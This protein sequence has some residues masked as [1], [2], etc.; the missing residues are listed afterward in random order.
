LHPFI[1]FIFRF[2]AACSGIALVAYTIATTIRVFVLPRGENA[3]LS[4]QVFRFVYQIFLLAAY[5]KKTY[6]ERDAIFALFAPVVLLIQPVIYMT[7]FA[8]GF[9]P[10]YWAIDK[11]PLSLFSL[12]EAFFLSGSSLTTLGFAAVDAHNSFLQMIAFSEAALGMIFVALLIAY[13]PTIYSAFSQR[14]TQVAML[15][16]RAGSPPDGVTMITRVFRNS[17]NHEALDPLWERWEQW[18][19]QIEESHTSL[20]ALVFFRSPMPDR[21]WVTAAGA[22]LDA[23]ALLDSTVDVPRSVASVL[24]IRAGYVSLRRIA[25]FFGFI[26]YNSSPSPD[27][28]VS[29]GQDE[30]DDA[31]DA[32]Q[33]AGVPVKADREQA[34][35]DYAGWRVNY[36]RVLL[37]LAR[38]T[39][40]PYAPWSSDRS[41][42][43]MKHIPGLLPSEGFEYKPQ[44]EK[45]AEQAR[46]AVVDK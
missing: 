44:Y 13:M 32:L 35:R 7:L 24:C 17:G 9:T 33:E 34:W 1:D 15:E 4:R 36:D 42:P 25:D 38:L 8:I 21:H 45:M 40:A 26:P 22:V 11:R 14:E 27:D 31:Y 39:S 5:K 10:L 6:L 19:A 16:V 28:P 30:F 20:V 46:T 18:F 43:D 29:I 12:E 41:L 2:A 3:W 23:A 37:G